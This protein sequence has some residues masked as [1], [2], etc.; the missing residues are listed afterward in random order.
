MYCYS[1]CMNAHSMVST[2]NWNHCMCR[3]YSRTICC[4][5]LSMTTGNLVRFATCPIHDQ[6]TNTRVNRIPRS[7]LSV[8][9]I[10]FVSFSCKKRFHYL[11]WTNHHHWEAKISSK[12][13]EQMACNKICEYIF[14]AKLHFHWWSLQTL[15]KNTSP[16]QSH[17]QIEQS[18]GKLDTCH[19]WVFYIDQ[20]DHLPVRQKGN[21]TPL[22]WWHV[23]SHPQS[24]VNIL[25]HEMQ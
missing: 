25:A 21:L 20:L 22:T 7:Q 18:T 9:G 4:F 16:L 8:P 13:E 14:Q 3:S 17:H 23:A 19:H 6:R 1:L 15:L 10:S 24:N 2:R 5:I 12:E 11:A